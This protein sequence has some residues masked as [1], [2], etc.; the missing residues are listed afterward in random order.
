[1]LFRGKCS[2]GFIK[3][4]WHCMPGA[5]QEGT[6]CGLSCVKINTLVMGRLVVLW[7]GIVPIRVMASQPFLCL[8][9]ASC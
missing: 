8:R 9:G 4:T 6:L 5:V 2:R 1:M 3:E 7:I